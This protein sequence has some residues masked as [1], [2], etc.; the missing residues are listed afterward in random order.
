LGEL[1]KDL[2]I[3]ADIKNKR[4]E[5]VAHVVRRDQG[6]TFKIFGSKR[7]GSRRRG[8]PRVR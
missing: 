2:D 3:G 4:F 7:E 8:R 6:R 5:W 1:Y